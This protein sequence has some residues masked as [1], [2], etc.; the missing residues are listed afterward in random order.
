MNAQGTEPGPGQEFGCYCPRPPRLEDAGK[1]IK[2]VFGR[3]TLAYTR[4]AKR[5]LKTSH[6]PGYYIPPECTLCS[7]PSPGAPLL[8]TAA[9]VGGEARAR[10]SPCG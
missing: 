6:P 2:A 8:V 5:V 4:R 7:D 1:R 9:V 3:V 10:A